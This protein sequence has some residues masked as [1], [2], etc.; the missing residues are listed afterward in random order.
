MHNEFAGTFNRMLTASG[1]YLTQVAAISGV[2]RSYLLRLSRGERQA[3]K[4]ETVVRIWIGLVFC[5]ELVRRDP[6]LVHGLAELLLA[7]GMTAASTQALA[8]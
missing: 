5:P 1:K 3:P 6:T 2:D 8:G 7:A 4:P